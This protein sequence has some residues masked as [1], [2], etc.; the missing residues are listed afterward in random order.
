MG[1]LHG[2]AVRRVANVAVALIIRALD[3]AIDAQ[4]EAIDESCRET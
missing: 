2:G 3:A 4:S 1:V